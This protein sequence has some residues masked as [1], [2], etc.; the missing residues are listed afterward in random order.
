[1]PLEEVPAPLAQTGTDRCS[2]CTAQ[3]AP[4]Q[5][6]CI[7]C[8]ERRTG[9]GLRE[10]LAR[11]QPIQAAA[12]ARRRRFGAA[13]SGSTS[14]IAGVGTLLLAMGVGVLIGRTGDNSAASGNAPVQVVTVPNGSGASAGGDAATA[15]TTTAG[16][17]KS[18]KSTAKKKAAAKSATDT[19]FRK[20][21]AKS[22]VKLPPP[23][24]KVGQPGKGKGYENGKFTGNYFGGE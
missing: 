15:A 3:M 18:S 7:K 17:A 23:V 19:S 1:M 16:S 6:Y 12:P 4:D 2:N 14:L 22:G 10:V 8:G 5:R 9:G 11:T 20:T 13:S 21:A 24:V